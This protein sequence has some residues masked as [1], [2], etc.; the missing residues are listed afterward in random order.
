MRAEVVIRSFKLQDGYL[1]VT[2]IIFYISWYKGS[3]CKIIYKVVIYK[4]SD[5]K[6]TEYFLVGQDD[7]SNETKGLTISWRLS[8]FD[9]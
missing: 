6:N 1:A 7:I 2:E 4:S 5:T 9:F 3:W 8:C